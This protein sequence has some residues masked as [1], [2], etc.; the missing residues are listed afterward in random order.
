MQVKK[1]E[2]RQRIIGVAMEL[3][4]EKGYESVSTNEIARLAKV[5]KGTIYTY[6]S[7]K[8]EIMRAVVD[9]IYEGLVD[10]IDSSLK[11]SNDLEQFLNNLVENLFENLE[12]RSRIL[13]IFH[14]SGVKVSRTD[15]QRKYTSALKK[16]YEKF[17]GKIRVNFESMYFF[18]TSFL[19]TSHIMSRE[20]SKET[21]KEIVK[22]GLKKLLI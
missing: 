4:A 16:A 14:R 12:I 13:Y 6:F 2:K 19:M 11:S 17:K 15:F 22:E 20:L 10:G 3:F 18:I 7:S 1:E 9:K 5:G 8:E 21:M